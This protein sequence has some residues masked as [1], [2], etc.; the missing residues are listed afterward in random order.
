M[1]L[2]PLLLV[3]IVLGISAAIQNIAGYVYV[4]FLIISLCVRYV[5]IALLERY[6]YTGNKERPTQCAYTGM[7]NY[8]LF[9]STFIYIFTYIYVLYPVFV[10]FDKKSPSIVMI[11]ILTIATVADFIAGVSWKCVGL[12]DVKAFIYNVFIA[13]V[14]ALSFVNMIPIEYTYVD[15]FA[16]VRSVYKMSKTSSSNVN[17]VL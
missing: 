16:G 2:S 4:L 3:L 7:R 6:I 12:G 1:F 9:L 15:V 13:T 10:N 5:L 17:R 14:L 8:G 11:V